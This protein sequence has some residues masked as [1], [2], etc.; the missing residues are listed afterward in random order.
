MN[1][2]MK[3]LCFNGIRLCINAAGGYN[4]DLANKLG[5]SKTT[6][7]NWLNRS[8]K[9]PIEWAIQCEKKLG[10]QKEVIRP[11]FNW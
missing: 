6:I 4:C 2:E 1:D 10:V 3:R 5:V 7:T 11:D 8:G 9:M